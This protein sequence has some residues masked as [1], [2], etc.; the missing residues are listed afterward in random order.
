MKSLEGRVAVVVNGGAE[1]GRSVALL[2]AAKGVHIVVCGPDE[3]TIAE[4]VGEI[5]YG[6]GKARHVV[7]DAM[8]ARARAREVFGEADFVVDCAG[9]PVAADGGP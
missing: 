5:A 1:P 3:K 2:L 4:T 6:G 7:G 8:A 9:A